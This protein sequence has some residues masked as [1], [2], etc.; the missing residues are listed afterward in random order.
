MSSR[1]GHDH[2]YLLIDHGVSPGIPDWMARLAGYDPKALKEGKR[3]EAKTLCCAHCRTHVVPNPGRVIE[4][5]SCAKCNNHYICDVCAFEAS[6][7]DYSHT[8]FEKKVDLA[9][10]GQPLGSPPKLLM[11]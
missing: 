10:S 9:L 5:A 8:P 7:P 3:F 2:G 6:R 4:R 11:P 1:F